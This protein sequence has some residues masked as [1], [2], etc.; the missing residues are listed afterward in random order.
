MDGQYIMG[1]MDTKKMA[2]LEKQWYSMKRE[3]A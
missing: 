3:Q 1:D 2:K